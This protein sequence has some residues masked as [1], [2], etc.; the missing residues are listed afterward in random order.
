MYSHRTVPSSDPHRRGG[1]AVTGVLR[2]VVEAAVNSY[3]GRLGQA[4]ASSQAG[5]YASGLAFT[6]FVSMFPLILGLV[7]ILSFITSEPDVRSH[8]IAGA[9]GVFPPDART[10]LTS[11]LDGIRD[12]SGLFGAIGII[13]LLWSGSSLFTSMEFALGRM[14]GARQRGFLRQRAMTAVMTVVF[15]VAIVSTIGLNSL[16]ALAGGV[17]HLAPV[18]GLLVWVALMTAIYRLAPNRTYPLR[19]LWPGALLAGALMEA[20]TLVWPL[21]AGLSHGFTTYGAAFALFFVLAAWLY[22]FAVFTLLGAVAIR[23]RAG[24]PTVKGL[25]ASRASDP[26]ET[27]AT[28]AADRLARRQ[29]L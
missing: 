20:L 5:N 18:L 27:D 13:G 16:A 22:F 19:E 7:S 1:A 23:M 24:A 4:F 25:I 14:I 28:R 12:H 8:F 15:V 17:P 29:S 6:A 26:I 9:L 2:R 3:P 10:A 11:A 21:Y